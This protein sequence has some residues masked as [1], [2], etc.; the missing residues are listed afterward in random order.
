M[1]IHFRI[2]APSLSPVTRM[3]SSLTTLRLKGFRGSESPI[4]T[5]AVVYPG[6]VVVFP[7]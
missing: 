4:Y 2:V 7:I 3:S 5:H 1:I 6:Y